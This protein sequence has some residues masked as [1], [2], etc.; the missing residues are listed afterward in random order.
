MGPVAGDPIET[1]TAL[2]ERIK[3]IIRDRIIQGR[4]LE[5]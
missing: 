3:R 4:V 2:I 1:A 5:I